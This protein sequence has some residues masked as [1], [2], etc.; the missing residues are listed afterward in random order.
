MRLENI[1]PFH[2]AL[3]R[4]LLLGYCWLLIPMRDYKL[5]S[6]WEVFPTFEFLRASYK[7]ITLVVHQMWMW[8]FGFRPV[9]LFP[10][11]SLSERKG[12]K[13]KETNTQQPKVLHET[14]ARSS[15]P[16]CS[17]VGLTGHM[18][19]C[20]KN[21]LMCILVCLEIPWIKSCSGLSYLLSFSRSWNHSQAS[22]W[23]E[24]GA[25]PVP[26][27]WAHW[28]NNKKNL[29]SLHCFPLPVWRDV[30]YWAESWPPYHI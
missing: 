18:Q 22:E 23:Y 21:C 10:K 19:N 1:F 11:K 16:V 27:V 9:D 4:F 8:P 29:F 24:S 3:L 26:S 2:S 30:L 14:V 20:I 17:G 12:N 6:L 7:I 28:N 15:S 25:A 13:S 5:N